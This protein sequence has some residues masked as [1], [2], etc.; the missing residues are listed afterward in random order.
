MN[1]GIINKCQ[2]GKS[3]SYP[4]ISKTTHHRPKILGKCNIRKR[5][6]ES[7]ELHWNLPV[8]FAVSLHHSWIQTNQ[9]TTQ[10]SIIT[11]FADTLNIVHVQVSKTFWL[12]VH[13]VMLNLISEYPSLQRP[14]L[15]R[16]QLHNPTCIHYRP[17]PKAIFIRIRM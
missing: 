1:A 17:L 12:Q 2:R 10:S 6:L 7:S 4:S 16:I 9:H 8:R 3:S 11:I 5:A 15:R 14:V 13:I